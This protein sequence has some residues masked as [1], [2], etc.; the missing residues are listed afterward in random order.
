MRLTLAIFYVRNTLVSW[1]YREH[2]AN[3]GWCPMDV[4]GLEH[5]D[6]RSCSFCRRVTHDHDVEEVLA[7]ASQ[8]TRKRWTQKLK[9]NIEA[10][11]KK[12]YFFEKF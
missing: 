6:E 7:D 11:L 12:H 4:E 8:H 3:P 9:S 1:S 2:D 10:D 5:L